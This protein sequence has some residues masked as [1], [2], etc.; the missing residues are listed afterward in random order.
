MPLVRLIHTAE[1]P[2]PLQGKRC[3]LGVSSWRMA[4]FGAEA[5]PALCSASSDHNF[6]SDI[7]CDV[8]GEQFVLLMFLWVRTW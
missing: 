7:C 2:K 8:S 1:E 6:L 4:F 3:N 5:S